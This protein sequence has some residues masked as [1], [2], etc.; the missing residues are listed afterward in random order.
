MLDI[1]GVQ[2]N[3]TECEEKRPS[4]FLITSKMRLSETQQS[5]VLFTEDSSINFNVNDTYADDIEDQL[6]SDIPPFEYKPNEFTTAQFLAHVAQPGP[7]ER[8]RYFK[9]KKE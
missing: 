4:E 6:E 5:R 1:R 3:R 8:Y 9:A 2:E 7:D